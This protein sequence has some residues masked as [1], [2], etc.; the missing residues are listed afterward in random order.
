MCQVNP[1]IQP[2]VA[3]P[4]V[5]RVESFP[6]LPRGAKPFDKGRLLAEGNRFE[7]YAARQVDTARPCSTDHCR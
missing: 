7:R 4:Q 2:A 5:K 3:I 1:S 6:A